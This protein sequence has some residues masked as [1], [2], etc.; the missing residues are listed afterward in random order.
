MSSYPV[1]LVDLRS[2][3][4]SSVEVSKSCKSSFPR[5]VFGL[6]NKITHSIEYEVVVD[7]S[8]AAQIQQI[9]D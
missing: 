3:S 8:S 5:R 1:S 9:V 7:V 2:T 4:E 6:A